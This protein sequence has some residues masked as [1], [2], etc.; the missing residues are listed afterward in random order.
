MKKMTKVLSVFLA[1]VMMVGMFTIGV[2]AEENNE[3]ECVHAFG[4]WIISQDE[5][6]AVPGIKYRACENCGFI[7]TGLVPAL[8]H[9]YGEETVVEPTCA[10][11]GYT[12]SVCV[13]CGD[14]KKENTVAKLSH[15]YGE[16]VVTTEA[17]CTTDGLKEKVC[18]NCAETTE[19]HKL[20]EVIPATG[21]DMQVETVVDPTYEEEGYT[22]YKCTA[23]GITD[24][25]DVTPVLA[26]RVLSVDLGEAIVINYE[27]AKELV[28]DVEMGGNV[29]YSI[30]YSSS[31]ENVATVDENGVVTGKGMGKAVITCTVTDAYGNTVSGTVNVQVK[32]TMANWF[33]I[34]RQVLQAAIDIVIG[35]LLG[36]LRK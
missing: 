12:F 32:F 3:A 35:G 19:G 22:I 17:T 34:I 1:L 6:C 2:N 14:V 21:H 7:E 18:L 23:C 11:E 29:G 20:T 5:T 30:T 9:T 8:G 4:K 31:A 26:G 25:R 36:S 15:V 24:K 13:N 28:P 33:T 16:W 10:S 27:Q